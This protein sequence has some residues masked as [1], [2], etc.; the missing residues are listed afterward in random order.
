MDHL[1][2]GVEALVLRAIGILLAACEALIERL[3]GDGRSGRRV[4]ERCRALHVGG[5]RLQRRDVSLRHRLVGRSHERRGRHGR[6]YAR[7]AL[8]PRDF[9][10]YPGTL[11]H[12]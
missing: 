2:A 11:S 3:S 12:P 1:F 10:A 4:A 8:L 6:T 7:E 9:R 5:S